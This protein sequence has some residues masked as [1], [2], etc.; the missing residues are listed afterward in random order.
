LLQGEKLEEMLLTWVG[1]VNVQNGT[2]ADEVT[3]EQVKVLGQQMS[4]ANFEH[5]NWCVFALKN[6]IRLKMNRPAV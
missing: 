3:K 2:A 6:Y 4:V 1:Q 5:K